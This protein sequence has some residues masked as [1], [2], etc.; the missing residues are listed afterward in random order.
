[1]NISD[2]V[3]I[4]IQIEHYTHC[5]LSLSGSVKKKKM[6]KEEETLFDPISDIKLKQYTHMHMYGH[7]CINIHHRCEIIN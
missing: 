3:D 1:M 5:L 7:M 2:V 6:K 4:A